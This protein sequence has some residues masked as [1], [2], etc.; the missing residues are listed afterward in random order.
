[1]A[2]HDILAAIAAEADKQIAALKAQ[3]ERTVADAQSNASRELERIT[4]DLR[5]QQTQKS[6]QVTRKAKQ[7]AEQIRRNAVLQ[8]KRKTL[9]AVYA[10]VVDSLS[11]ESDATLE[12]LFEAL[13]S[14]QSG[15]EILP[16]KKHAALL[17][18]LIAGKQRFTLGESIDAKGGFLC[19]SKTREEDCRLESIVHDIVR[20]RT[21]LAVSAQLFSVPKIL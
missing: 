7:Q 19:V 12:P 4:A 5:A 18:K 1:M 21:E 8:H 11:K 9:G 13:L 20:P 16:A 3:H 10:S 14:R 17:K 2:L 15:G 6:L